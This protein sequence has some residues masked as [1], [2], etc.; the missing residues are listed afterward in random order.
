MEKFE[1]LKFMQLFGNCACIKYLGKD[2]LKGPVDNVDCRNLDVIKLLLNNK[3]YETLMT[4]TYKTEPHIPMFEKDS[5]TKYLFDFVHILHINP[6]TEKH[7]EQLKLRIDRFN[8]F[9]KKVK[10]N[11]NYYFTIS[12]NEALVDRHSHKLN[13]KL[14]LAIIK[15]L[16]EQKLLSKCIFVS[17]R[18]IKGHNDWNYWSPEFIKIAK[19]YKLKYVEIKDLSL[20]HQDT[21]QK[22]FKW[23]ICKILNLQPKTNLE[24][25]KYLY[26]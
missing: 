5:D 9:Y 26:F 8:D 25:N 24:K 7:K 13:K 15:Y 3:Y 10:T 22:Q 11:K 1:N 23:Q 14:C 18:L 2:R 6:F 19:Q 20:F 12:L 4:A 16:Q 21:S 17:T